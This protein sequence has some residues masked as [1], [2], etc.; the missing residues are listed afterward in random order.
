MAQ[1]LVLAHF[2]GRGLMKTELPDTALSTPSFDRLRRM[3][4]LVRDDSTQLFH[5]MNQFNPFAAEE[6][7]RLLEAL[8]QIH[9]DLEAGLPER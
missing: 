8:L 5:D 7:R 9:R 2:L 4:D 6:R 1:T 3:V